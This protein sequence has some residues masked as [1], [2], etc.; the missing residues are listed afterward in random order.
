M[1]TENL[2]EDGARIYW[3]YTGERA[4][5]KGWVIRTAHDDIIEVGSMTH[6]GRTGRI[7]DAVPVDVSEIEWRY[8]DP[9]DLSAA[10]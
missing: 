6:S 3:R 2:P 4:W 8:V 1:N 7:I 9:T 5:R 10:G